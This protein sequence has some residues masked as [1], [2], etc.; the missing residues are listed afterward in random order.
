MNQPPT[1]PKVGCFLL[2][3]TP[4]FSN[5]WV[6]GGTDQRLPARS[7]LRIECLKKLILKEKGKPRNKQSKKGGIRTHETKRMHMNT[8]A[9]QKEK[10]TAKS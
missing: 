9:K 8:R 7:D 5:C 1:A 10:A 6:A 3:Q 4:H 2:L